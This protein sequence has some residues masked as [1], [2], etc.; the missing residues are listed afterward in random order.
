MN[1]RLVVKKKFLNVTFNLQ[2]FFSLKYIRGKEIRNITEFMK[3]ELKMKRIYK[4]MKGA[5]FR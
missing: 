4:I 1:Y 3:F 5:R 2:N